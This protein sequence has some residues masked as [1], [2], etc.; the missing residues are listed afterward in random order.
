MDQVEHREYDDYRRARV[1]QLGPGVWKH[2]KTST[3]PSYR[4]NDPYYCQNAEVG[5]YLPSKIPPHGA[6]RLPASFDLPPRGIVELTDDD[7]NEALGGADLLRDRAVAKGYKEVYGSKGGR[8]DQRVGALGEVAL[9]RALGV[10]WSPQPGTHGR[11]SDV[12]GWQVRTR[13]GANCLCL[14]PELKDLR[15]PFML[16]QII[17]HP[18]T[19][20]IAGWIWGVDGHQSPWYGLKNDGKSYLYWVPANWLH[21]QPETT[22]VETPAPSD[23]RPAP[24]GDDAAAGSRQGQPLPGVP[25]GR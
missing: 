25:D 17:H 16:V 13:R 9:A 6:R 22:H 8:E 19:L 23:P 21:D 15:W 20:N 18:H 11:T 12:H 2:T 14:Q 1:E 5:L 3:N 7:V 4:H 10:H 24:S